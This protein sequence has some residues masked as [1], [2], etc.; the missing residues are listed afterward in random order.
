V[1]GFRRLIYDAEVTNEAAKHCQRANPARKRGFVL[2]FKPMI[3]W[4]RLDRP[5]GMAGSPK[6]TGCPRA[7]SPEGQIGDAL[8]VFNTEISGEALRGGGKSLTVSS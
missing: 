2:H 5:S 8:L 1:L 6:K 3:G 7:A 4:V